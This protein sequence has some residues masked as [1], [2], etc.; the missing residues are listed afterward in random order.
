MTQ[1]QLFAT[2]QTILTSDDYYTPLWLFELL[3]IEFDV[4]VASPPHKTNVPCK[5]YYTQADNGLVQP[6]QGNVWMNPPFRNT[7]PWAYKFMDHQHGICLV[8]MSKTKWFNNLWSQC[9][10]IVP[11][12]NN[13]TFQQ[14][15]IFLGTVLCAYGTK[16]VEALTRIGRTR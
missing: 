7:A 15:A 4:D 14:G 11:L 8:P 10:A 1:H 3:D 2:P 9:D 6:W 5:K 16:N 13:F 12:P